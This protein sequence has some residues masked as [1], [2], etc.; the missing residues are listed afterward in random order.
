MEQYFSFA[1]KL[2]YLS[3]IN[4]LFYLDIMAKSDVK[5]YFAE[6]LLSLFGKERILKALKVANKYADEKAKERVLS[7]QSYFDA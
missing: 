7:V 5:D 6:K 4:I 1:D 2:T 3:P